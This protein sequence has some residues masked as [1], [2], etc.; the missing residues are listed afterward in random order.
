MWIRRRAES[1][2]LP[3]DQIIV[4]SPAG[5]PYLVPEVVLPFQAKP[6]GPRTT[7]TSPVSCP[8]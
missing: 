8:C 2:R 1:I 3:Y 5:V 7:P 4:T 6:A